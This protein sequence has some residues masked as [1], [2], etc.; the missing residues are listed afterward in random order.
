MNIPEKH[1]STLKIETA[2]ISETLVPTYESTRR[3]TQKK[4]LSHIILSAMGI[5][6]YLFIYFI[7]LLS[8]Y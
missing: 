3:Q 7:Y 4:T 1:T 5:P 6:A 2:Y 8:V